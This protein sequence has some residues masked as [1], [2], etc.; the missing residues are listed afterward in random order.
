MCRRVGS[1]GPGSVACSPE[2][3][4]RER[5]IQQ[6]A[7]GVAVVSLVIAIAAGG[8]AWRCDRRRSAGVSAS[9]HVSASDL[10]K[11][12]PGAMVQVSGGVR[13]TE[14]TLAAA[15]GLAPGDTIAAISGRPVT[16]VHELDGILRE[17]AIFRPQRLFLELVRDGESVVERW[18]IDGDLD[19]ARRTQRA[20]RAPGPSDPRVA[21]IQQVDRTTYAVPRA[22]VEAWAS[23]PA[24]VTS[25]G[26]GV[27][28]LGRGE[29]SGFR[30]YAIRPGSAYAAL[31][32]EDGDVIRMI[33]GTPLGSADQVLALVAGSD[34]QVTV[35]LERAG[36][37]MV[38][39]YLIK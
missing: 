39:N 3:S 36:R 18:E 23:D 5:R 22:T 34:R 21:T 31:G 19:V 1:P 37:A 17:L 6:I 16:R 14:G 29:H 35:D 38:L 2:M 24:Q 13:V 15:L 25:G 9:R 4:Q 33:N 12:Q 10:A 8:A 7:V 28:V 11:L 27:P 32:L 30:I 26:R 20:D